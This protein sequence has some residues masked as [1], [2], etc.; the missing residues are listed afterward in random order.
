MHTSSTPQRTHTIPDASFSHHEAYA[1]RLVEDTPSPTPSKRVSRNPQLTDVFV[2]HVLRGCHS[3]AARSTRS[4]A[5]SDTLRPPSAGP[6]Q[7]GGPVLGEI[8]PNNQALRPGSNRYRPS[9]TPSLTKRKAE[10]ILQDHGSPPGLR[11]TAGGRIVPSDQSP[12]CSPRFGYSAIQKNGSLIRF[13][14]NYPPPPSGAAGLQESSRTLPNGFVAQDPSGRLLQVVDGQFL[15]VNEVN[16]L[17][18]LYIAAPNLNN[19]P[20]KTR[21]D[22][23]QPRSSQDPSTSSAPGSRMRQP[24]LTTAIQIQALDKQYSK[25]EQESR[26]LDKLEVLQRSTM[27]SKAYQQLINT[28][29]ELVTRLNEIRISLKALRDQQKNSPEQTSPHTEERASPPQQHMAPF[30]AVPMLSHGQMQQGPLTGWS[31]DGLTP[32]NQGI[33]PF[34][35]GAMPIPPEMGYYMPQPGL[36]PGHMPPYSSMAASHGPYPPM[37]NLM[38]MS[39][40]EAYHGFANVSGAATHMFPNQAPMAPMGRGTDSAEETRKSARKSP[41]GAASSDKD[42]PRRS[43]ALEIRNPEIKLESS[44]GNKSSLNPM[45]PSYQPASLSAKPA[46][47]RSKPARTQADSPSPALAEAVRAHNAW[48]GESRS[49]NNSGN[50][51]RGFRYESSNASFATADFFPNNPRDHSVNKQDYPV[52]GNRSMSSIKRTDEGLASTPDRTPVTP[53]KERHNPNWNPTIPDAAFESLVTPAVEQEVTIAPPGTPTK[54]D[55]SCDDPVNDRSLHNMSPKCRRQNLLPSTEYGD[56][57]LAKAGPVTA[58]STVDRLVQERSESSLTTRL[59]TSNSGSTYM[60][61]FRA[62]ETRLPIGPER[63]GIWL[64][65]YCA[66]LRSSMKTMEKKTD[67]AAGEASAPVPPMKVMAQTNTLSLQPEQHDVP[68]QHSA[69]DANINTV[70]KLREAVFSSQ[71]ENV[72]L[73]P[74]SSGPAAD[75]MTSKLGS[76]SRQYEEP[77]STESVLAQMR[78]GEAN[79]PERTSSMVQRQLVGPSHVEGKPKAVAGGESSA[80]PEPRRNFSVQ[81][82]PTGGS[83]SSYLRTVYPGNRVLSS[84][85]EWKSGSS[86]AQVAGLAHGYVAQY[87]GTLNDLAALGNVAPLTRMSG[88]VGSIVTDPKESTKKT[89]SPQATR[90]VE[91]SMRTDEPASSSPLPSPTRKSPTKAKFAQIAGKA[92]IKV[93]MEDQMDEERASP[94]EKA[95]WRDVWRKGH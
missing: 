83:Q 46:T 31:F 11:V 71:N 89:T 72:L 36:F 18:Q 9:P 19:F 60:E 54:A 25:L 94:K 55:A 73:S 87:D 77:T 30:A 27:S 64:D 69:L 21:G 81:S 53:E 88:N 37:F 76:R 4:F 56:S 80:I 61:G 3:F 29:R 49:V 51:Q 75:E 22:S 6:R 17:P 50:S 45:S 42:S 44:Q 52:A 32:D 28:R 84:Q 74:E 59:P 15:S 43:H 2:D 47:P 90:F 40:T 93:R 63:S 7:N 23:T 13:A 70:N 95:R 68:S 10:L 85:L 20:G 41:Y 24:T 66:G 48:V 8:D 1:L 86:I 35:G 33:L 91:G 5:A 39:P 79:F 14:P 26:D 38:G 82:Q 12:L 67:L 62:G 16:G 58:S 57:D 34:A 92:G 78:N 65:G